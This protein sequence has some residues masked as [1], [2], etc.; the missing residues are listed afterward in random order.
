MQYTDDQFIVLLMTFSS[1]PPG[2]DSISQ[3]RST[4]LSLGTPDLSAITSLATRA[5]KR[6][7]R[8]RYEPPGPDGLGAKFY[9][10]RKLP[11]GSPFVVLRDKEVCFETQIQLSGIVPSRISRTDKVSACFKLQKM[12]FE[13]K[14]EI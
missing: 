10:P 7:Y 4:L 2:S 1:D 13:G 11:D 12:V 6:V 8:A 9:F 3:Y 14:L 5:G